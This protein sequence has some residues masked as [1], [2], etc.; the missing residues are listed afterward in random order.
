MP[1]KRQSYHILRKEQAFKRT[2]KPEYP[3]P[4][5]FPSEE[6]RND[7][8]EPLA[9]GQLPPAYR[10][11]TAAAGEAQQGAHTHILPCRGKQRAEEQ[12]QHK[13]PGEGR[14]PCRPAGAGSGEHTL[15]E[16]RARWRT[17]I[18]K[19]PAAPPSGGPGRP[20]LTANPP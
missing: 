2:A 14:A 19:H 8:T 1:E 15:K 11:G 9:G 12:P 3:T 6:R 16:E 13:G 7:L 18:P 20:Y 10:N 5:A 4:I 17:E